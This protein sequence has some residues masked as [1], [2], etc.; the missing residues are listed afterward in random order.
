[1]KQ[2]HL[3]AVK[4]LLTGNVRY[5]VRRNMFFEKMIVLEVEE[6]I[7]EIYSY[8]N[9]LDDYKTIVYYVWRKAEVEDMNSAMNGIG[10]GNV[11]VRMFS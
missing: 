2:F 8:M 11:K 9:Y 3:S 4:K 6:Q 10:E 1:M 7:S 5:I